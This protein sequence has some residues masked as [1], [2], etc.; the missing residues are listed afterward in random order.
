MSYL[1]FM[2]KV[3]SIRNSRTA[4][5]ASLNEEKKSKQKVSTKNLVDKMTA[6]QKAELIKILEGM[7]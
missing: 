2:E 3:K 6:E 5:A 1:E 4:M 7:D